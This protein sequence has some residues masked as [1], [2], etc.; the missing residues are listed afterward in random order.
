MKRRGA[1][2]G[3]GMGLALGLALLWQPCGRLPAGEAEAEAAFERWLDLQESVETWKADVVQTRTFPTLAHPLESKGNILYRTPSHFRWRLGDPPRT[4]A[5]RNMEGVVIYYPALKRAEKYALTSGAGAE[6][7]W[8]ESMALLDA[9]FNQSRADL[10]KQFDVV[11]LS[12][13]GGQGRIVLR[14]KNAAARKFMPEIRVEF[15]ESV[16]GPSS[17]EFVFAD[18]ATLRNEFRDPVLNP[19]L[20]ADAFELSLPDDVKISR[21]LSQ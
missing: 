15:V 16:P 8:K 2:I 18:G 9:G 5:V 6:N 3:R 17:T 1:R 12:A 21:P 7:P 11:S 10:E 20:D 4:I 13:S 19:K 14:P